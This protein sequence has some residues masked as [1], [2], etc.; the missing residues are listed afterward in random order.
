MTGNLPI[1]LYLIGT[2][3]VALAVSFGITPAVKRFAQ[4]IGAIA[5]PKDSRRMHKVPIPRLG[6]LAIFFGF[7]VSI[8]IFGNITLPVRGMLLG[9][10]I[11]VALGVI[12]DIM[13]LRAGLKFVVQIAA[14]LVAVYHGNLVDTI[15][16]PN[17]FSA[18]PICTWA[19]WPFLLP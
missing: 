14:A 7:I 4:K 6:G 15:S 9:S 10:V 12:D 17:I 16:N 8:L 11:I 5:V 1:L 18:Q 19:F 3:L 2:L 13:P